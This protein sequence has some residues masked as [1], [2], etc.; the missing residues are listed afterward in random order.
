AAKADGGRLALPKTV[1]IMSVGRLGFTAN[2][3][4]ATDVAK[5]RGIHFE[6]MEGAFWCQCM[7]RL[8]LSHM[9]DGTEW[10]LTMDYDSVF[11][12]RHFDA[13]ANLMLKHPEADAIAPLQMQRENSTIMA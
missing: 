3:F 11:E 5:E 10:L 7:E 12:I 4:S 2:M 8:M 1:A 13:L 6:K 9:D